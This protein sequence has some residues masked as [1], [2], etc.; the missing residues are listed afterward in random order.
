MSSE[1]LALAIVCTAIVFDD[2][3]AE[4][5]PKRRRVWKRKWV[6]RRE[7][8]GFCAKLYKR[9]ANKKVFY[10]LLFDVYILH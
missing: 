4:T 7:E 3:E 5:K 8:E 10:N 6:E 2:D 9:K 1:E